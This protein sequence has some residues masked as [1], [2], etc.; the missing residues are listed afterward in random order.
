ML[1]IGVRKLPIYVLTFLAFGAACERA[2][3]ETA[4]T[5]LA[6]VQASGGSSLPGDS[7]PSLLDARV[8]RA[9][10]GDAQWKYVQRAKAD[11]DGDGADETAVLIADVA[12]DSRGVPLWDDGHRWQLYIEE[13]DSTRTYVYARFLPHGILEAAVTASRTGSPTIVLREITP[14]AFGVYEVG[15]STSRQVHVVRHLERELDPGKGFT[16]SR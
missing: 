12:L 13:S 3:T 9:I 10:A 1:V 5:S 7:A 11:F 15:Y 16:T 6:G 4:D 8:P 2:S 14:H